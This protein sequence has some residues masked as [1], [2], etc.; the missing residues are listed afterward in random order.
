MTGDGA[1]ARLD[2]IAI[3]VDDLEKAKA[4]FGALGMELRERRRWEAARSTASS[5]WTACEPPSR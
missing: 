3:V 2:N 4:F 1:A 5:G